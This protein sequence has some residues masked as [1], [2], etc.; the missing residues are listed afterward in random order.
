MDAVRPETT[1]VRLR[2]A[3]QRQVALPGRVA[4]AVTGTVRDLT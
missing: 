1:G 3:R 4:P 2:R